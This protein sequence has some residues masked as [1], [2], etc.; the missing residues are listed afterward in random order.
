M[1]HC[2]EPHGKLANKQRLFKAEQFLS[3]GDLKGLRL[4]FRD[5]DRLGV[6]SCLRLY[7]YMSAWQRSPLCSCRKQHKRSQA[8]NNA[9]MREEHKKTNVEH[10][11]MKSFN[12]LDV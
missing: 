6:S 4:Y 5:V 8:I 10:V 9:G 11:E 7:L 12:F 3:W 2:A 1:D